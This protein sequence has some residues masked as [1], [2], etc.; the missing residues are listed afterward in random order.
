MKSVDT[1]NSRGEHEYEGLVGVYRRK[2]L[3]DADGRDGMTHH[4]RS[5]KGGQRYET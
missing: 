5:A 2:A 3:R 4:S 1:Q